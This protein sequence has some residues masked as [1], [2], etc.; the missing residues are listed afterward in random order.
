MSTVT[1]EV[2]RDII[3]QFIAVLEVEEKDSWFPQ[4]GEP[5]HTATK[6][7]EFLRTFFSDRIISTGIWPPRSP[8]VSAPD[9]FLRGHLKNCVFRKPVGSAEEL[10][11]R[12][13]AEIRGVTPEMLQNGFQNFQKKIALCKGQHC[14]HFQQFL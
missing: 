3:T 9:Y 1:A 8:D 14:S 6:T 4:D 7:L 12:I 11:D 2:Y 5:T 10:K 13:T